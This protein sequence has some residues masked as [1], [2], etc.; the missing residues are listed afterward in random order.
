MSL[1]APMH[2]M[3]GTG[4]LT[5]SRMS[6]EMYTMVLTL[7]GAARPSY[8]ADSTRSRNLTT[9]WDLAPRPEWEGQHGTALRWRPKRRDMF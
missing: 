7:A 5:V 6:M 3:T 2:R 8:F 1:P 9:S 4:Y